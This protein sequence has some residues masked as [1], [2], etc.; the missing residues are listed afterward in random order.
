M[1]GHVVREVRWE[2]QG[3]HMQHLT[4]ESKL[5]SHWRRM[6]EMV[7]WS[8]FIIKRHCDYCVEKSQK[9]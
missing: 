3:I 9:G 5:G 6:N 2:G 8:D 7:E 4:G 1:I